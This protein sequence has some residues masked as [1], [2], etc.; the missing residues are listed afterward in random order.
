MAAKLFR[1]TPHKIAI[2]LHLVAESCTIHSPRS[3]RPVRKLFDTPLYIFTNLGDGFSRNLPFVSSLLLFGI[4]HK[5]MD[6]QKFRNHFC[7][8]QNTL[9]FKSISFHA[10]FISYIY[11]VLNSLY[12]GLFHVSLYTSQHA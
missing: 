6:F 1:L 10:V 7:Q 8:G 11:Y 4:L 12:L 5:S 2:Q 3:R 9:C